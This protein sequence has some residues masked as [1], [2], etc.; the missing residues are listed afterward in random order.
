MGHFFLAIS[1]SAQ[2]FVYL[3]VVARLL[4]LS[5]Q[6]LLIRIYKW[7]IRDSNNNL[8]KKGKR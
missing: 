7:Q 8:H 2:Y 5:A 4:G 1:V 3:Q 6:L